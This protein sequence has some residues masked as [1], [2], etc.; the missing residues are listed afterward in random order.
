MEK[1]FVNNYLANNGKYFP[2]SK[3]NN[4]GSILENSILPEYSINRRFFNPLLFTI[5]FWLFLPFQ[6]IDRIILRDYF[7]GFLKL[8]ALPI[9]LIIFWVYSPK[10]GYTQFNDPI[11]II[12]FGGFVVWGIWT[13]VDGFTIY[14]R[15]KYANYYALLASLKVNDNDYVS[16][17][18]KMAEKPSYR[19][20]NASKS[21]AE[22]KI[23]NPNQSIN[24]YYKQN[25]P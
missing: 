10:I 23:K 11:V 3:L 15:T 6:L 20:R 5:I 25:K 16:K 2:T 8:L 24:E 13:V 21:L 4:I 22:W 18:V 7:W 12:A 17:S 9:I 19:D 1:A 14:R